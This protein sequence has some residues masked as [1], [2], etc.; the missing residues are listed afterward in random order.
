[1][2][3]LIVRQH[4][5]SGQAALGYL[6]EFRSACFGL[7]G[8]LVFQLPTEIA[9]RNRRQLR[10]RAYTLLREL[11]VSERF[12]YGR[13]GLHPVR[14]FAVP[15]TRMETAVAASGGVVVQAA[16]WPSRRREGPLLADYVRRHRSSSCSNAR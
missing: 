6:V 12:L 16:S 9:L 14:M 4:M 10:R 13:A 11:G 7:V 3:S 5:P 15:R 8:L 1:M 2:L